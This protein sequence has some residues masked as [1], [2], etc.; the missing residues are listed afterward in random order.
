M[1]HVNQTRTVIIKIR[2]IV[3]PTVLNFANL[4]SLSNTSSTLECPA[5]QV[6]NPTGWAHLVQHLSAIDLE[7]EGPLTSQDDLSLSAYACLKYNLI[8]VSGQDGLNC[9]WDF[10]GQL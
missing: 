2:R 9:R 6:W 8:T 7:R 3:Q 10:I 1:I 5:S 4:F